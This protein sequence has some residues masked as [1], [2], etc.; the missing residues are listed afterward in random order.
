M[1]F[2][3]KFEHPRPLPT[4]RN[5]YPW[6]VAERGDW[7]LVYG[8]AGADRIRNSVSACA[9]DARKRLDWHPR[10]ATRKKS[11]HVLMVERV[12]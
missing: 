3:G 8:E 12:A 10:F 6:L 5:C 7:W 4:Q 9:A 2:L 11:P 1:K